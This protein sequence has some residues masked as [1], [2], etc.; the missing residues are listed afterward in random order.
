MEDSYG[1]LWF[2]SKGGL[3]NFNPE[4]ER[5]LRFGSRAEIHML[6]G[7]TIT[8]LLESKSRR[9]W[10]GTT[11]GINSI[12]LIDNVIENTDLRGLQIHCIEQFDEI[13]WAGTN[14]GL[15][16]KT[17]SSPVFQAVAIERVDSTNLEVRAIATDIDGNIWV[18]VGN[19]LFKAGMY[20][21]YKDWACIVQP[22]DFGEQ[23]DQI[24]NLVID[25]NE[26]IWLG[27]SNG[28]YRF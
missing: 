24:E 27:C 12:N 16:M 22:E 15:F 26:K 19:G 6:A 8:C 23:I 10:V 9:L 7:D 1:R 11:T 18:G 25:E 14:Q 2:G 4:T 17:K 13:I 28:L 21:N 5:F 20:E 3:T